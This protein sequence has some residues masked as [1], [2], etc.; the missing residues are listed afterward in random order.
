MGCAVRGGDKVLLAALLSGY[1]GKSGHLP[2]FKIE[3]LDKNLTFRIVCMSKAILFL[4]EG[5]LLYGMLFSIK[6]FVGKLS[7]TDMK[8]GFTCYKTSKYRLNF[9]ETP[10]KYKFV[11]NTDTAVTHPIVRDLLQNMYSKVFVEYVIKNPM[12]VPGGSVNCQLFDTRVDEFVKAAS[13]YK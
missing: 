5:K 6:S 9:Y 11:L 8:D 3:F 1:L 12:H 7:P 10:S 4:Q 13:F 2:R